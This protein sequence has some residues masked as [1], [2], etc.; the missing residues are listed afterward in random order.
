MLYILDS[1]SFNYTWKGRTFYLFF[2]WLLFLEL[3]LAWEKL[4]QKNLASL[5]KSRIVAIGVTASIPVVYVIGVNLLGLNS[6]LIEL[7]KQ[8]GTYWHHDWP[9]SLEYLVFA[10]FF[11]ATIWLAY[12]VDGLKQFSISL[13]LLGAIGTIYMIDT[14]YPYGTFTPFQ[15]FVTTHSVIG[16]T[17]SKLDG[18]HNILYAPP[19]GVH[20]SLRCLVSQAKPHLG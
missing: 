5:R 12:K 18:L 10:I 1:G 7:G 9:L 13:C 20:L 2:L 11:T 8:I 4:T 6:I 14:F 16:G 17:S 3:I 19:V 15:A